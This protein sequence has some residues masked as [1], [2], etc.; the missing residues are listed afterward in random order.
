MAFFEWHEK[1]T[2]KVSGTNLK[3]V[4]AGKLLFWVALGSYFSA[5]LSGYAYIFLVLGVLF[6]LYYS[7]TSFI[8]YLKNQKIKYTGHISGFVGGLFLT[9]FLGISTPALPYP[10]YL[11]VLGILLGLPALGNILKK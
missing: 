5:E 7:T 9:L 11:I 3:L 8:N 2:K 4:I 6:S 1:V 10:L